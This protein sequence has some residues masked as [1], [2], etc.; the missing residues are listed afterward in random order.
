MLNKEE[1]IK[2]LEQEINKTKERLNK[3][4][5][6]SEQDYLNG[7]IDGLLIAIRT[8]EAK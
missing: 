4:K 5:V 2:E 3:E 1:L 7:T 8:L 6:K